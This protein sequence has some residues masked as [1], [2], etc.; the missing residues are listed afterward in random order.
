MACCRTI[1]ARSLATTA[2]KVALSSCC[3]FPVPAKPFLTTPKPQKPRRP[4]S[5]HHQAGTN[6][7]VSV[8]PSADKKQLR[9]E[10]C[11]SGD[12]P[13]VHGMR[14]PAIQTL[15]NGEPRRAVRTDSLCLE[16]VE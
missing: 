8:V 13:I 2:L 14:S 12:N 4:K 10:N 9:L 16:G 15:R 7:V 1:K 6:A 5:E 11:K 3:A